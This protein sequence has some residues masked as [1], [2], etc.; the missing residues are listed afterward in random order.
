[1]TTA[2]TLPSVLDDRPGPSLEQVPEA[3]LSPTGP[4]VG[5]GNPFDATE[6]SA[7]ARRAQ[8]VRGSRA[9]S[10]PVS[11]HHDDPLLQLRAPG[12][13]RAPVDP[14]LAGG[15][16]AWLEDAATMLRPDDC[17]VIVTPDRHAAAEG[18][19]ASSF[20]VARHAIARTIFRM[21]LT[22][23]MPGDPFDDALVALCAGGTGLRSIELIQSMSGKDLASLRGVA[24][25]DAHQIAATWRRPAARWLPRTAER[26]CV[27]LAAG[28]IELRV[29]ADLVLGTP[30]RGTASVCLVEV[31][32]G[33]PAALHARSRRFI[34]LAETLRSGAPPF[35]VAT[36]H[37][38]P[39]LL[40]TEEVSDA[41]LVA[42][43]E[44]AVDA[45]AHRAA[46]EVSE[47]G[48]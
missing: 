8:R 2:A 30:S 9:P 26:I 21:V 10:V 34:A 18:D 20:A 45:I 47:R 42:A 7:R 22:G 19:L 25:A 1:M 33:A 48:Q 46:T 16:R 13:S 15:L 41:M 29:T 23:A 3:V 36:Y 4:V 32:A 31:G 6:R 27:P 40:V 5:D 39:S 37:P 43:V 14:G 44:D 28:A 38:G 12:A 35:R 11:L 24:R 17:R